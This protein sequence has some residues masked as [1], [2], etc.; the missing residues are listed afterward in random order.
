MATMTA[1]II[2][3]SIERDWREVMLHGRPREDAALATGLSSGLTRDGDG[4][5]RTRASRHARVRF[6]AD[7]EFVVVDHLVTLG[8]GARVHNALRVVPNGDGAE[9]MF[10]LLRQAGMT[11][12]QFAD[13]AAGSK[14]ILPR[15]K[16]ILETGNHK[17][18]AAKPMASKGNDKRIDYVEFNVTDIAAKQGLLRQRLRLDLHGLRPGILRVRRRAV[19]GRFHHTWSGSQRR[20]ARHHLCRPDRGRSANGRSAGG[21]ILKPIFTFP[22]GRRF[23]FADPDAMSW[24][25]GPRSSVSL[26]IREGG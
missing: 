8:N 18:E 4:V 20:S 19:D 13:D 14:R 17:Q 22:G 23:H 12:A 15:S 5:D 3:T 9:V 6:V 2:H 25:C 7:N 21:K 24:R 26:F 11:D 16:S 10:T 1:R